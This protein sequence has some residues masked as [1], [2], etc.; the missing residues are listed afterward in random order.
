MKNCGTCEKLGKNVTHC[1]TCNTKVE[2]FPLKSPFSPYQHCSWAIFQRTRGVPWIFPTGWNQR[3]RERGCS[4]HQWGTQLWKRGRW[5]YQY[6][7]PTLW[8]QNRIINISIIDIPFCHTEL[9]MFAGLG[10]D[11]V[12]MS[13]IPESLVAHHCGM[14]VAIISHEGLTLVAIVIN[15]SSS[16]SSYKSSGINHHYDQN[17]E[18]LAFSLVTNQC[19]LDPVLH[20]SAAPNHQVSLSLSSSAR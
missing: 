1:H 17:V 19:H 9:K 12:G 5:Y 13:S 6:Q 11:C 14:K 3:Y 15:S 16:S 8:F 10:V 7:L 4:D 18:V 2:I 20:S